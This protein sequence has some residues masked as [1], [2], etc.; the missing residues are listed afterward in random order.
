M[1]TSPAISCQCGGRR[2]NGVCDRCGPRKRT[3]HKLKTTERGYG[4]DWQKFVRQRKAEGHVLC[5]DCL[6][7][8]LVR[9]ATERHHM[10]KIKLDP[11]KRLDPENIRDLCDNCHDARTAKGE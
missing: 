10:V 5:E 1:P 11:S 4:H 9:V 2:K 7:N 8:G 6:E 3:P